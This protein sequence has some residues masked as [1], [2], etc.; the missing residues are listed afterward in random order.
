MNLKLEDFKKII[1]YKALIKY[2]ENEI[3]GLETLINLEEFYIEN[4]FISEIKGLKN[5]IKLDY[6]NIR[7]PTQMKP[8]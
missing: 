6:L 8:F 7:V 1:K 2:F 5:L 3:K 4:N